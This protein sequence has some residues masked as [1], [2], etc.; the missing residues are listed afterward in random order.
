M[1]CSEVINVLFQKVGFTLTPKMD[2]SGMVYPADI[3]A[4]PNIEYLGLMFSPGEL[5]KEKIMKE[6]IKGARI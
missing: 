5:T 6:L 4:S 1:F 2:R 3:L